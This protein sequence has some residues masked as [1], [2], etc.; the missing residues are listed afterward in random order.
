M[1]ARVI[2]VIET[3]ERRGTGVYER[4]PVRV[5]RQYYD[6]DGRLLWE[7][8]DRWG[9]FPGLPSPPPEEHPK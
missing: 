1:S 9:A 6:F 8:P 7:E 5:I 3:E 4:D 2:Q